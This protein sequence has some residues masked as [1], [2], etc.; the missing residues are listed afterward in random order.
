M[1]YCLF[2][3]LLSLVP[4]PQ[5]SGWLF[6]MPQA[7]Y[8]SCIPFFFNLMENGIFLKDSVFRI[9]STR[10]S[11]LCTNNQP[12]C[13]ILSEGVYHSPFMTYDPLSK[14]KLKIRN[15]SW[16]LML[17]WPVNKSLVKWLWC[18]NK[19]QLVDVIALDLITLLLSYR[20]GLYLMKTFDNFLMQ[21]K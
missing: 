7:E 2:S 15:G 14:I 1:Y 13:R 6:F 17:P 20:G 21:W 9:A 11:T 10:N 3:S 19:H 16:K 18:Q 8:Q 5:I 4:A 12:S